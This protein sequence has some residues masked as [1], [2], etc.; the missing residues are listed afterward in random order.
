MIAANAALV[1]VPTAYATSHSALVTVIAAVVAIVF[2]ALRVAQFE[3]GAVTVVDVRWWRVTP[4][5]D[6]VA[7]R[8]LPSRR[9]PFCP[10]G[11]PLYR[12]DDLPASV[13]ATVS[14][15]ATDRRRPA[16]GQQPIA[17]Y[18]TGYQ[19]TGLYTVADAEAKPPLPPGRQAAFEAA[20][21]CAECGK[22]SRTPFEQGPSGDRLCGGCIEP[23]SER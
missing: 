6:R 1:G 3:D 10:D 8:L 19:H 20:R 17:T 22:G 5:P 21:T 4:M 14:M 7:K 18:Y 2:V 13:L 9:Q 12:R 15:L 16:S 23:V 11:R